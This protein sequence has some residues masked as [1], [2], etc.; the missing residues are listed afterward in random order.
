MSAPTLSIVVPTLNEA[1][2]LP[3]M[4][5]SIAAM[6]PPALDVVVADGGS[7]DET[8]AL[9]REAGIVVLE[10]VRRGRA[11]QMN[12]GAKAARGDHLC[13]LHADTPAPRDL[14]KT[15]QAT[16]ERQ[17]TACGGFVSIMRG[18]DRTRWV[19]SAHNYLKT[20]Y[21]PALFRPISFWKGA[22]LLFGDQAIFCRSEDFHAIGGYDDTQS[23]MEEADF[24]L[25]MVRAKRGRV[26][27]IHRLIYSSDRRV[28]AWGGLGANL[29]YL[30]IGV[31]W[32][33]GTPPDKLAKRYRD[34]R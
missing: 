12:A 18:P 15:I 26:R 13:F 6:D 10:N 4:L 5:A 11:A 34:V 7:T 23:I 20:Y 2:A 30:E 21:A 24:L 16:L 22:R 17:E 14:A 19:T 1:K 8:V 29:K 31:L 32:G 27:Q 3:E 28:S 25:R 9:A 33:L